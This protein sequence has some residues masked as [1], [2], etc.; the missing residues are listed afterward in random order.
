V[1]N[2]KLEFLENGFEHTS[3]RNIASNVG[4]SVAG[5]YKLFENKEALFDEVVKS[6]VDRLNNYYEDVKEK[7][8][9]KLDVGDIDGFLETSSIE[10]VLEIVYADFDAF[11]LIICC[12]MG[13]KYETFLH[14]LV[15]REQ[16]D[17][18]IFVL[19]AIKKG[20]PIRAVRSEH[21]H[22]LMRA[23]YGAL[24]DVVRHDYT[25][26]EAMDFLCTLKKFFKPGWREIF[27]V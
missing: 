13:T 3:M 6:A 16:E 12:S 17:T 19:R 20:I 18:E 25:R 9:N 11:K 2:A 27:R 22:I 5:L 7:S 14:D 24:F 21:M 8:I 1:A 26:E 10:D 23:Y 4:I 15:V